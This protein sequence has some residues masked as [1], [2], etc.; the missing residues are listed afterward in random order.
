MVS[1]SRARWDLHRKRHC[2]ALSSGVT[3]SAT[4][5]AHH[6]HAVRRAFVARLRRVLRAVA[7][8][9]SNRFAEGLLRGD[10]E[11]AHRLEIGPP[12][13]SNCGGQHRGDAKLRAAGRVDGGARQ[14]PEG[15]RAA[16]NADF[17]AAAHA[18]TIQVSRAVA[19]M[20]PDA[21]PPP[22]SR[23]RSAERTD[24]RHLPE[25]CKRHREDRTTGSAAP[26]PGFVPIKSKTD[27]LFVGLPTSNNNPPAVAFA[28]QPR[29][30]IPERVGTL[31]LLYDNR[32]VGF[33]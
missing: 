15:A 9:L 31:R 29:A 3:E 21:T 28:P 14:R 24:C 25:L 30:T 1:C 16:V 20:K 11:L 6:R 32:A 8:E 19:G 13:H 4:A 26:R 22:E 18:G 23:S 33:S 7:T 10:V 12:D 27:R 2:G 5:L 17:S